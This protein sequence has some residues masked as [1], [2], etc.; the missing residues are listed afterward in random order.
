MLGSITAASVFAEIMMDETQPN[1]FL[2][3]EGPDE[4]AI[5]FG[6][7]APDVVLIVCGGKKCVLGASSLAEAGGF[8]NVYGLVDSDFER[9][10]GVTDGR[11]DHVVS[12]ASYDLV[13]DLLASSPGVLRRSLS[14]HAADQ[15]RDIEAITSSSVED[16][17]Y[18]ITSHVAGARLASMRE[19]FPLIFKG[20]SFAPVV[21]D[22]YSPTSH[23]TFLHN[24]R[25]TDSTFAIDS[26]VV[27]ASLLAYDDVAED[28]SLSGG[29]DVV[30][31]S[32]AILCRAGFQ[33][34]ARTVGGTLISAAT[35]AVLLSLSCIRS[36]AARARADSGVELFSCAASP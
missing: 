7:V 28:R 19:A 14:A 5:L 16:V 4:N 27:A 25:C 1:A 10:L 12:T 8:K 36:L 33:I 24:A 20:Y 32:A 29:H 13:A 2:L 22:Q 3:V 30:G 15:V 11:S 9:V 18:S 17:V 23:E 21:T 34:S 26:S 31:A 6:H 35:C